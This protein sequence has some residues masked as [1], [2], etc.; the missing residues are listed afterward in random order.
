M[1]NTSSFNLSLA[2][3]AAP[4]IWGSMQDVSGMTF[5][6]AGAPFLV[7]NQP[8]GAK[9]VM[10]LKGRLSQVIYSSGKSLTYN[11]DDAGNRT[12]VVTA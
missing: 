1:S 6:S 2:Y 12:S 7:A 11:Y 4:F 9:Y 8:P 3:Q 10:D 5:V